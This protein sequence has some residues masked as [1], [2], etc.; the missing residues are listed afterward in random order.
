MHFLLL[1][2]KGEVHTHTH[3]HTHML[4]T[5]A[6]SLGL[7]QE[8]LHLEVMEEEELK[9]GTPPARKTCLSEAHAQIGPPL[10]R[11]V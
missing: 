11:D 9:H 1:S 5:F 3:T 6:F 2:S 8:L 4:L 7:G 10:P